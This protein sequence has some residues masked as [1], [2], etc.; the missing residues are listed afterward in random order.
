MWKSPN[1][2]GGSFIEGAARILAGVPVRE[3]NL[4]EKRVNS[5]TVGEEAFVSVAGVPF[6][7]DVSKAEGDGGD[8]GCHRLVFIFYPKTGNVRRAPM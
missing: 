8:R 2:F 6:D 5:L 4:L 1:E 3:A 7:K